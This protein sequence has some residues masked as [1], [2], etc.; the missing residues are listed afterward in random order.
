M[1]HNQENRK[2]ACWRIL[3]K[4]HN[5]PWRPVE[6]WEVK[7]NLTWSQQITVRQKSKTN[8]QTNTQIKSV[9]TKET[10]N[11]T[12][13]RGQCWHF[14]EAGRRKILAEYW[15]IGLHRHIFLEMRRATRLRLLKLAV[16]TYRLFVAICWSWRFR[17]RRPIPKANT[18][19]P[20]LL[21]ASAGL[22]TRSCEMPSVMTTRAWKEGKIQIDPLKVRANDSR[23][24]KPKNQR[25]CLII[26]YIVYTISFCWL[27]SYRSAYRLQKGNNT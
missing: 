4:M 25:T 18:H 17:Y 23:I 7:N 10:F 14:F 8:K 6:T 2:G 3:R 12:S 24:A 13:L 22:R 16:N 20:W 15:V 5:L 11:K 1:N 26:H 27:S 21:K 19:T 9:Q